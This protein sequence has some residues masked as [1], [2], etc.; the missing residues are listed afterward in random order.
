MHPGFLFL[1]SVPW[2]ELVRAAPKMMDS[3]VKLYQSLS[4]RKP[5]RAPQGT[6]KVDDIPALRADVTELQERLDTLEDNNEAQA[7]LIT[8]MTRHE[9]GL[10][11]WLIVLAFTSVVTGVIAIAA[12][13]VAVLQ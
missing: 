3:A 1:T 8:Q 7:E 2:T 13:V 6:S 9:A 4:E 10:L 12:I 11:R 5:R